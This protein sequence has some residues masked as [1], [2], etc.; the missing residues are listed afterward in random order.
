MNHR[1]LIRRCESARPRWV[2]DPYLPCIRRG[3]PLGRP[4]SLP[5]SLP[6]SATTSLGFFP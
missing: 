6:G 2:F 1:K 5:E 3:D 4:L